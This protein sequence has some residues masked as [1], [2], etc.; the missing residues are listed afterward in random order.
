MSFGQFLLEE[1]IE[2]EVVGKLEEVLTIV[3]RE[4]P[5]FSYEK[6]RYII[7]FA[8][9]SMGSGQ[10]PYWKFLVKPY[11]IE[12]NRLI[13]APICVVEVDGSGPGGCVI[14]IPS[15]HEWSNETGKEFDQE[16]EY[17]TSFIF[18]FLNTLQDAKL[19]SLPGHLPVA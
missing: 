7:D 11:D 9:A 14:K 5:T 19:I 6:Y 18:Q 15:R 3:D 8:K 4:V 2:V 17:F 1:G 10:A 13:D 16:G 12:E